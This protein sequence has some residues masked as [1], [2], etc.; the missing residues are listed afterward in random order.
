[1]KKVVIL[2]AGMVGRTMAID[3]AK[4]HTVTSVDISV[5]ALKQL[6][7]KGI[8]TIQF[9]LGDSAMFFPSCWEYAAWYI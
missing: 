6:K 4:K 1:M 8:N 5:D 3:L 9:D 2:G 7:E